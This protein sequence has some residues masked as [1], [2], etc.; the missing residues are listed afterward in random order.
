MQIY[1]TP[2][3]YQCVHAYFPRARTKGLFSPRSLCRS[4][5]LSLSFSFHLSLSVFF[6]LQNSRSEE[7]GYKSRIPPRESLRR[8][9]DARQDVCVAEN[10]RRITWQQPD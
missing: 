1:L 7:I 3:A 2:Y 10:A 6:V 5:S 4:L 9:A 8:V